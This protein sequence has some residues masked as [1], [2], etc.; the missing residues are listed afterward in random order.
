M[1]QGC[2]PH[3]GMPA[4]TLP[5]LDASTHT[6]PTAL[7]REEALVQGHQRAH[8]VVQRLGA[9]AD[10]AAARAAQLA[11]REVDDVALG[12]QE[13]GVEQPREGSG[14]ECSEALGPGIS[15]AR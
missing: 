8:L 4:A 15:I 6:T 13:R 12:R 10:A 3:S 14:G 5:Q 2:A 11:G 9:D 1:H 7:S